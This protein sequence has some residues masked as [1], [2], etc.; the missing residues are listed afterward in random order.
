M[1]QSYSFQWVPVWRGLLLAR[2]PTHTACCRP[3]NQLTE[4]L[5]AISHPIS[6]PPPLNPLCMCVLGQGEDSRGQ[7]GECGP[8]PFDPHNPLFQTRLWFIAVLILRAVVS[9]VLRWLML[10]SRLPG[11][12]FWLIWV[13]IQASVKI[14]FI[15]ALS[16]MLYA[17]ALH[18]ESPLR[19][20]RNKKVLL[21]ISTYRGPE[22]DMIYMV[23][24]IQ[25]DVG[26]KDWLV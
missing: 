16:R 18:E 3:G 21:A 17:W 15:K 11:I 14:I 5:A 26:S 6:L 2:Q 8:H 1:M 7:E 12:D 10:V 22:F 23:N 4:H 25:Q 20:Y 13:P 19:R 9:C 24:V